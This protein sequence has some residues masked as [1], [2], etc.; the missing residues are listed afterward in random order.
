MYR[1]IRDLRED[2][3]CFKKTLPN[4][5]NVRRSAILTMKWA[6]ATFQQTF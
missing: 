3:T 2:T 4:I 5:Y 6:S 1:R